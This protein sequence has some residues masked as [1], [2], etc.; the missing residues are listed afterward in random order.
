MANFNFNKII[1]G[2]RIVSAP[3]LKT[4][5]NGT[6]VTTVK[7]AVNRM[8]KDQKK[9]DFFRV[10]AWRQQAEILANF[11]NKGSSVCII[12]SLHNEEYTTK[13]GEKRHMAEIVANEVFFVDSRNEAQEVQAV[14]LGDISVSAEKNPPLTASFTELASDGDLPF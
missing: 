4:T 7:V 14:E 10:T 8:S 1:I 9:A 2:G 11:F 3:E 13:E 5:A 12:G 6:P